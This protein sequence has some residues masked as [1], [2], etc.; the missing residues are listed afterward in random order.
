LEIRQRPT[1]KGHL[2]HQKETKPE[3]G[4][5]GGE[6]PLPLKGG[7][8]GGKLLSFSRTCDLLCRGNGLQHR[9]G[10]K[11]SEYPLE[12]RKRRLLPE[13]EAKKRTD[14]RR[15]CGGK[16]GRFHPGESWKRKAPTEGPTKRLTLGVKR[17]NGSCGRYSL[18]FLPKRG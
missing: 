12:G 3:K 11:T 14:S 5:R 17:G 16:T 10:E 2:S 13:E 18:I 7:E 1:S 8:G 6:V 4:R 15:R 9:K